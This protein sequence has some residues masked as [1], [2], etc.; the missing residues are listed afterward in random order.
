M[1]SADPHRPG[2]SEQLKYLDSAQGQLAPPPFDLD[3]IV[4]GGRRRHRRRM[5][6]NATGAAAAVIAVVAAVALGPLGR[7]GADGTPP[8]QIAGPSVTVSPTPNVAPILAEAAN[9]RYT[10]SGKTVT[11]SLEGKTVATLKLK[12]WSET[13][14]GVEVVFIAEATTRPFTFEAMNFTLGV[15]SD[16]SDNEHPAVN[17]ETVEIPVGRKEVALEFDTSE[18]AEVL[19]WTMQRPD[20]L[21]GDGVVMMWTLTDEDKT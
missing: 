17:L 15:N 9:L 3:D 7:G 8:P 5:A 2:L 13:R 16:S 11:V 21:D 19:I 12:S 4:R 20:D 1:N 6:L 10:S 14:T 18:P